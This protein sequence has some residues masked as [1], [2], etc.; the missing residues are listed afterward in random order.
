[1]GRSSCPLGALHQDVSEEQPK[2]AAVGPAASRWRLRGLA[3]DSAAKVGSWMALTNYA[4]LGVY[5][6]GALAGLILSSCERAGR[7]WRIGWRDRTSG[8]W[9]Y[10]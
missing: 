3:Q 10:G 8:W 9:A 4:Q 1:M 6:H 5:Q 2:E 7:S